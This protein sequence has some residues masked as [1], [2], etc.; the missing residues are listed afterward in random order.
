MNDNVSELRANTRGDWIKQLDELGVDPL[1]I[2]AGNEEGEMIVLNKLENV[3]EAIGF[4]EAAKT[5]LIFGED[6]E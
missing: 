6:V 1:I 5:Q 2:V 3:M 4:L